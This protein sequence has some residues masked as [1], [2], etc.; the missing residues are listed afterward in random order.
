MRDSLYVALLCYGVVALI[1]FMH[2]VGLWQD[3]RNG[4]LLNGEPYQ[5]VRRRVLHVILSPFWPWWY[6]PAVARKIGDLASDFFS[7]PYEDDSWPICKWRGC[8]NDPLPGEKFCE[9][10]RARILGK[11]A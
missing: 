7:S 10:H 9:R 5:G 8:P 6:V 4:T 1:R 2:A 11:S 3:E